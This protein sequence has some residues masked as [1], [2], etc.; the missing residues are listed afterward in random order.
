MSADLPRAEPR[1]RCASAWCARVVRTF[2][3]LAGAGN[4]HVLSVESEVEMANRRYFWVK[5]QWD[6]EDNLFR[7]ESN[8]IGLH[9]EAPTLDEFQEIMTD[10]VP[11]L[12][13]ANHVDVSKEHFPE[14]TAPVWNYEYGEQ[15]LPT[16]H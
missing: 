12:V 6:A 1:A 3:T 5:A 13:A 14:Y 10:L 16:S 11:E 15:L 9:I 8:V 2:V 7:S 4:W